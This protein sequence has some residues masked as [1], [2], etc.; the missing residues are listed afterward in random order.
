MMV[1]LR[2]LQWHNWWDFLEMRT[3][4]ETKNFKFA[5]ERRREFDSFN[6]WRAALKAVPGYEPER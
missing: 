3:V 1:S 6:Q 5:V 2:S 4:S